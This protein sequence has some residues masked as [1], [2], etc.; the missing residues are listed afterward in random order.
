MAAINQMLKQR[1]EK[2]FPNAKVRLQDSGAEPALKALLNGE[3]DLAA[4]GRSLTADEKAQGLIELPLSRD[5]IAIVV[6]QENPFEGSLTL[7]QL[8]KIF[9][10]EIANWAEVGGAAGPI[11]VID[12]PAGSDTRLALQQYR[13]FGDAFQ[14]ETVTRLAHR[15]HGGDAGAA[16]R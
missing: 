1:Y 5:Q 16:R 3:L 14:A 12:R 7:D 4:V 2:Q 10:G 11:R 15:R 9:R 8:S 6:G 13:G